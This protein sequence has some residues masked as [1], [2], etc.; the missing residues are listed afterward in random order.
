M[1]NAFSLNYYFD[2]VR[3]FKKSH[4]VGQIRKLLKL[5]LYELKTLSRGDWQYLQRAKL[6]YLET[7][8]FSSF[9]TN[10]LQVSFLQYRKLNS[11]K[12]MSEKQTKKFVFML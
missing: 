1:K 12:T 5:Q 9:A 6:N 7:Q 11:L 4:T 2:N 8:F 10:K 3:T